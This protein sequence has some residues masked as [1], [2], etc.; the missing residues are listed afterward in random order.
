MLEVLNSKLQ[1]FI[2]IM[3]A[4]LVQDVSQ[5]FNDRLKALNQSTQELTS[6]WKLY[7]DD[8]KFDRQLAKQQLGTRELREHLG[9]QVEL[10]HSFVTDM[11]SA[12][13]EWGMPKPTEMAV[14][15]ATT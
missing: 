12:F 4:K 7:I 6:K 8:S 2:G 14:T 5:I 15:K 9:E 13:A 3:V 11:A 10:H 1:T